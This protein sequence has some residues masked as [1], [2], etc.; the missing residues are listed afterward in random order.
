MT[1]TNEYITV[2]EYATRRGVSVSSVYKRLGGTLKQYY[3]E[4]DGKKCI[5]VQALV[6][7]GFTPPVERVENQDTTPPAVLVALEVLEKQLAEKDLQIAR[8]QAEAQ[9]LRKSN[10]EKD[11]FIQEQAGKMVLLLEQAQEL[12]RNNQV[13]LGVEKGITPKVERVEE[14]FTP[15]V[16]PQENPGEE[17]APASQNEAPPA[18]TAGTEPRRGFWGRLFGGKKK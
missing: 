11:I 2:A 14:G 6:E 10:A 16:E 7:E 12:N 18:E 17:E 1:P 8:L 5:S 9:E 15:P 13:L 3:K 4:I